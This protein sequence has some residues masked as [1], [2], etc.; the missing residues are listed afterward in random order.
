MSSL[1]HGKPRPHEV[2]HRNKYAGFIKQRT[3]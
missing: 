3:A 2:G 1:H